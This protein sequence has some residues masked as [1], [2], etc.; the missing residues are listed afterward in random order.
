MSCAKIMVVFEFLNLK[1]SLT[2]AAR[3]EADWL[4]G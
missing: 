4:T 3:M 2:F 1:E